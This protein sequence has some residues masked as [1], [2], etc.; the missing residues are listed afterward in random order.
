MNTR[1][2]TGAATVLVAASAV[3]AEDVTKI[4]APAPTLADVTWIKGDPLP[5]GEYQSGEVYVL[6]FWA[7]WCGPCIA[8]IPHVNELQTKYRKDGLNVIAVAIWPRN[9]MTP[10]K[11]FVEQRGDEM[12][13][14]V[15]EDIDGKTAASFMEATGQGGIPTVMIVDREG[16]LAWIGHPMEMDEPLAQIMAGEFDMAA[17]VRAF[18]VQQKGAKIQDRLRVAF[19]QEDW[20]NAATAARELYELDP[21]ANS[22]WAVYEYAALVKQGDAEKS[23]KAGLRLVSDILSEDPQALNAMA[24]MIVTPER[25]LFTEKERDLGLALIAA[26]KATELTEWGDA[27]VLDTL[28]RVHFVSG[29]V[30]K[31]I[32]TQKM[33]VDKSAE[34]FR[35]SYQA[36]LAEYERALNEG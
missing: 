14:R 11:D 3:L 34:R 4:G 2:L 33:A 25:P 23:A 31:A 8:A 5:N 36:R 30:E 19:M 1:F 6:D 18:E 15:A 26:T 21:E 27:D 29:N 22:G 16:T 28:A 7:T 20:P 9:G 32:E 24:W 13:Y 17:S 10:T 35:E 12:N